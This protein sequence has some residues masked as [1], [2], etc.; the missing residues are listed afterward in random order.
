MSNQTIPL[1]SDKVAPH[2]SVEKNTAADAHRFDY[3]LTAAVIN[4]TGPGVN[5]RLRS[6]I[7]NLTRHLHA[8]CRESEITRDE[9]MAA[10]DMVG[11]NVQCVHHCSV[12]NAVYADQPGWQDVRREAQ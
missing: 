2:A 5:L 12:V 10:I 6:V 9:F 11:S 8:F 4:A 1:Y 7:A 3:G